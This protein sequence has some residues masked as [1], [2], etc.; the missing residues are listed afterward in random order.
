MMGLEMIREVGT[1][2]DVASLDEEPD[3]WRR[4]VLFYRTETICSERG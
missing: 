2:G 3:A 1:G 4:K